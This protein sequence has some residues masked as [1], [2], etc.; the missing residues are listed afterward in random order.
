MFNNFILKAT[1]IYYR[2]EKISNGKNKH[3]GS[4]GSYLGFGVLGELPHG[5]GGV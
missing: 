4:L 1:C 5:N 2:N 3:N